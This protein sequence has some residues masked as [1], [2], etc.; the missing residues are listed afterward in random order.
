[1]KELMK[2]FMKYKFLLLLTLFTSL[3]FQV[4]KGDGFVE[5]FKDKKVLIGVGIAVLF[6][7]FLYY[8]KYIK[9]ENTKK[10]IEKNLEKLNES[11][12]TMEPE[13][14]ARVEKLVKDAGKL[15]EEK[16]VLK[17]LHEKTD[18]KVQ[19]SILMGQQSESLII[20][21]P[22]YKIMTG[23]IGPKDFVVGQ[24]IFQEAKKTSSEKT[25][26][27]TGLPH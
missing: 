14:F 17:E 20:T 8:W 10:T 27:T 2:S 22:L 16:V 7:G 18:K 19:Y 21:V 6:G 25:N 13:E 9:P 15:S 5:K 23:N 24:D 11:H 12:Q 1:M 26:N 4:I 3:N